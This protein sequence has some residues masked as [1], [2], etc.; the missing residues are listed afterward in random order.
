MVVDN[1]DNF[2]SLDGVDWRPAR[3]LPVQR[4]AILFTTCNANP[5]ENLA[6]VP[7]GDAG[8]EV[9]VMNDAEALKM[10]SNRR[11]TDGLDDEED[12]VELL[13]RLEKL[14]LAIAQAVAY[15]RET[16]TGITGYLKLFKECERNQQQ[17]MNEAL[18]TAMEDGKRPGSRAVMTTWILTIDEIQEKSPKPVQL[19]EAMSF[20]NPDEIPKA[21]LRDIPFLGDESDIGFNKAFAPL[22]NFSLIY[23]LE[24]SNYRLHRLVGLCIRQQMDRKGGRRRR[25][26]LEAATVN[27]LGLQY[28]LGIILG[29]NG[30]IAGSMWLQ[31][32]LNGYEKTLGKYHI[33]TLDAVYGT[34]TTIEKRGDNIKA[35][36]G[37][38]RALDGNEEILGKDHRGTLNTVHGMA[39][40]FRVQGDYHT[41]LVSFQRALDGYETTLGKD[42]RGTLNAFHGMAVTFYLQREYHKALVSF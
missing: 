19:L 18:P 34:A 31:R 37:L 23:Q 42:H 32:A 22:L 27:G 5:V 1:F 38:Q 3:H 11:A 15:M 9:H 24:S 8:V 10:L 30:N 36:V 21:L 7:R 2:D 39:V 17:L 6:Y 26:L 29:Q 14:S 25:D 41:A 20:L 4:G 12:A 28:N 40:T 13:Q 16:G 33:S 35:Y